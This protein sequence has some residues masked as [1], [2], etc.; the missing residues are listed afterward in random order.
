MTRSKS[1]QLSFVLIL[2]LI[3]TFSILH[4]MRAQGRGESDAPKGNHVLLEVSDE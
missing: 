2:A 1:N 4:S 3:L